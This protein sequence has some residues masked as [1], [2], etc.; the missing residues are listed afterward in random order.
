MICSGIGRTAG[1]P[2]LCS[3]THPFV[4]VGERIERYSE[5]GREEEFNELFLAIGIPAAVIL[6][7]LHFATLSVSGV[8]GGI[9][10]GVASD[11][12]TVTGNAS[13]DW[14]DMNLHRPFKTNARPPEHLS[15]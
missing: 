15:D 3:V 1:K 11:L 7:P 9:A 13:W 12:N 5:G 8:V 4:T 10:S 2:V 14:E 6:V